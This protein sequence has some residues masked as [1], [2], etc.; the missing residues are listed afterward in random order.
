MIDI[1]ALPVF[2]VAV[3]ALLVV[4]GPDF[5]LIS[6]QSVSRGARY[7]VACSVGIFL[8]GVLQTLL[9]AAGLGK[10]METW[11]V[12]AT[13][14]R[15]LGAAYLAYLG[16]KLLLTWCRGRAVPEQRVPVAT[17]SAAVLLVVGLANN[18]LNPKALLFFSVF[19]PQFVDPG[20]GS[21]SAQMAIWGGLLSVLALAYNVLLSLLFSAVRSLRIDVPRLQKH[22]QGILGVLFLLLAARLSWAKAA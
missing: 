8:A 22:G 17:Q 9:V 21:P 11:P 16:I 20:L 4:P 13:A 12:V 6:S 2:L 15:L 1:S 5:L 18:L 14:V 19:I 3:A 7:G 10:V